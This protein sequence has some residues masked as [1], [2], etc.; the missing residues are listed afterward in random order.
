MIRSLH[1]EAAILREPVLVDFQIRHD[2]DARDDSRR[3]FFRK[4]HC[5]MEDAVNTISNNNFLFCGLDMNIG[6]ALDNR[7]LDQRIDNPDNREVFRH[8]FKIFSICFSGFR[9]NGCHLRTAAF[10]HDVLKIPF[11]RFLI[12]L[13]SFLD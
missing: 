6:R 1:F 13:Y 8:L 4:N 10:F 11:K 2:F 9:W 7:M 12:L 5:I 3:N